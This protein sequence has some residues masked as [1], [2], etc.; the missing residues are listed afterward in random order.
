MAFFIDG[1]RHTEGVHW[2]S[3]LVADW[4][5]VW[6]WAWRPKTPQRHSR[7]ASTSGRKQATERLESACGARS[8]CGLPSAYRCLTYGIYPH[9]TPSQTRQRM[10]CPKYEIAKQRGRLTERECGARS[11]KSVLSKHSRLTEPEASDRYD[12]TQ[13]LVRSNPNW[14]DQEG[15]Q[16]AQKTIK[17]QLK[18]AGKQRGQGQAGMDS[19]GG[20][21]SRNSER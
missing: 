18:I 13:R 10:A 14:K 21:G 8:S 19:Q 16:A 17:E 1:R 15:Y 2:P 11:Y 20:R 4:P 6:V 7:I 12:R 9:R 3:E 5:T